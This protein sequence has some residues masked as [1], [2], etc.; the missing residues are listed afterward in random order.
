MHNLS[1][2]VLWTFSSISAYSDLNVTF[3]NYWCST[4]VKLPLK[5]MSVIVIAYKKTSFWKELKLSI[6]NVI[7]WLSI[8]KLVAHAVVKVKVL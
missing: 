4:E 2:P 1:F 3:Y 8:I 5:L 7:M 6:I